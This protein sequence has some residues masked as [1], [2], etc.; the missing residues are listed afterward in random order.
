M[1]LIASQ[2]SIHK[3]S[4]LSPFVIF[5]INAI[6]VDGISGLFGMKNMFTS[7]KYLATGCEGSNIYV[8]QT[9]RLI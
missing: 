8:H 1:L 7:E 2:C 3:R 9:W 5:T 6:L 4:L